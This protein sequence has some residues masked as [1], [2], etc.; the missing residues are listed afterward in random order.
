MY[1]RPAVSQRTVG[2]V[3]SPTAPVP[4]AVRAA[5]E[6]APTDV[7]C[8]P[9]DQLPNDLAMAIAA[10]DA[11]LTT[12]P[13][14]LPVLAVD[15]PPG[16]PSVA[17][18][19]LESTLSDLL[20]RPA[21][22]RPPQQSRLILEVTVGETVS[23]V[24]REVTMVTDEPARISEFEIGRVATDET[25][26]QGDPTVDARRRAQVRADGVVI[27]TPAGSHGYARAAG[28]P[29]LAP[30]TGLAVI[31]LAP[32]EVDPDQ[33]ILPPETVTC[34][35]RRDAVPIAVEADGDEIA[36]AHNG[37]TITVRADH[38]VSV[39]IP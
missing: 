13:S 26:R 16:I 8:G 18:E 28:S 31:P 9:G 15:L 39:L 19:D 12:V 24:A 21:A 3:E 25:V 30:G 37:D 32:F 34:R 5:A 2:I 14:R 22:D 27:A 11:A 38:T 29:T 20:A 10:S 36:S 6:A 4:D 1:Y 7:V 33:W 17:T 35:I 23:H